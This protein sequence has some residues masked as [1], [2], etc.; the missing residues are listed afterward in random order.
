MACFTRT[1]RTAALLS[2]AWPR[3]PIV[4]L[5]PDERVVRRLALFHGVLSRS[6]GVPVDTDQML[7]MMEGALRATGCAG[8]G[9]PAVLVAAT[10]FGRAHTNLLKVHRVSA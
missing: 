8:P 6:C 4:A 5:S 1:G 3:V 9:D 10:P 7:A 2:G